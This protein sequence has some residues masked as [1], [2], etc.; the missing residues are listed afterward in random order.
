MDKKTDGAFP[1]NN[2]YRFEKT[3]E[4]LYDRYN[5]IRSRKKR[6]ETEEKQGKRAEGLGNTD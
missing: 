2:P 1:Y 5:S 3:S 4:F 6:I